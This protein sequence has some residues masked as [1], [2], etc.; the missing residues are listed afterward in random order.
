[1]DRAELKCSASRVE[2][3]AAGILGE[4]KG[5]QAREVVITLE[6]YEK[7][8]DRM[9]ADEAAGFGDLAE[10]EADETDQPP[11]PS[12]VSEGQKEY[13]VVEDDAWKPVPDI[14]L[15][16]DVLEGDKGPL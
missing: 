2:M 9:D 13:I 11:E 15:S 6:E 10:E 5:S 8:R 4:Y 3:A 7:L 1:M 14:T 12:Y 16:D